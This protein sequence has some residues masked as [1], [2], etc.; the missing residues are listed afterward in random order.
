[1][2]AEK[3]FGQRIVQVIQASTKRIHSLAGMGNRFLA[4]LF[5]KEDL[6]RIE[7]FAN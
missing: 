5:K 1:M 7:T 6:R 4:F 3:F 2:S